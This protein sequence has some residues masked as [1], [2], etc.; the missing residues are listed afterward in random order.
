M[1]IGTTVDAVDM[2]PTPRKDVN[3]HE[4]TEDTER[5]WIEKVKIEK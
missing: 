4:G 2:V 3:H 5:S 1:N